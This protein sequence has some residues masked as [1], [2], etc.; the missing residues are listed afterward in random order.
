MANEKVEILGISFSTSAERDVLEL[1]RES[2]RTRSNLTILQA[3][4]FNAVL[5]WNDTT[6]LE[7]YRRYDLALPDGVGMFLAGKFLF[8][9]GKSFSEILN[10]TDLY[11]SLLKEA[12]QCHWR[13]FFFGETE[14]VL[15]SLRRRLQNELSGVFVAGTHHGYVDLN[16]RTIAS[17]ISS[18][19]PD[20]LIVGMGTPRQDVWLWKH[21]QELHVPVILTVGAG[22]GFMS[23]E[24][25]RAPK[26]LRKLHLEWLFRLLQEPRRLWKRYVLGI[27]KF[28]FYIFLQKARQK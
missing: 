2:I 15:D 20:I 16:D 21:A 22:I 3:H 24:K 13:M 26:A 8:G 1:I 6:I 5:G 10:G 7:L 11:E 28:I 19:N 14:R 9:E 27:P 4:F 12:N 18:T 17:A 25:T 23:G